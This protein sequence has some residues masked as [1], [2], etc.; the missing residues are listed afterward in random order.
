VRYYNS[1]LVVVEVVE[2][3]ASGTVSDRLQNRQ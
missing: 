2:M 1:V 3:D